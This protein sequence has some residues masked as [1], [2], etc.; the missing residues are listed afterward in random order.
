MEIEIRIHR[1]LALL[2][3]VGGTVWALFA[4]MHAEVA[5]D[6]ARP[7]GGQEGTVEPTT[8]EA[9][10]D[11]R[12]LRAEQ[13]VLAQREEI[14]RA[15]LS[16]LQAEQLDVGSDDPEVAFQVRETTQRLVALLHDQRAAD[17]ELLRSLRELWEAQ[18]R[19]R[20]AS[21]ADGP[22][23]R[24]L[25]WPVS[26]T[27]GISAHFHDAGYRKRFGMEH[28]AVDIPVEQGSAV[29]AAADGTVRTVSDRGMGF[30][31]LVIEHAGGVSTL[32]GHVSSFLVQEGQT[33]RAGEPVALSGGRPGTPGAGMFTTGPHLHFEVHRD[34]EAVDPMGYLQAEE[35]P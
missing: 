19:A 25:L 2:L 34:G 5:A 28:E 21:F 15:Q 13:A 11:V 16:A 8:Q 7:V 31:A 9:E 4:A 3:I 17:A 14:L 23:P 6:A 35:L 1:P 20:S 24:A 30:N 18:G 12:A 26:P 29:R 10:R 32:Y 33:V 22:P 27:L